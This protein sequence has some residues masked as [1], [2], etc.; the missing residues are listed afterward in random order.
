M[1][2]IFTSLACGNG[3]NPGFFFNCGIGFEKQVHSYWDMSLLLSEGLTTEP[4]IQWGIES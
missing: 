3:E 4:V 2:M 1:N